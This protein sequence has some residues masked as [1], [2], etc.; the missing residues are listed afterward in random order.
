MACGVFAAPPR[1]P[2]LPNHYHKK[3]LKS[4][5]NVKLK[6]G[7]HLRCKRELDHMS[8]I[9]TQWHKC[10]HTNKNMLILEL[11]FVFPSVCMN[12][13]VLRLCLLHKWNPGLTTEHLTRRKLG[14]LACLR[15][16][17][18]SVTF[19]VFNKGEFN[20]DL[21]NLNFCWSRRRSLASFDHGLNLWSHG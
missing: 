20:G 6:H 4:R 18:S 10:R 1:P 9:S 5:T 8:F 16:E 12:S 13:C 7:F 19:E 21:R 3:T 15:S 11:A 17:K 14:P 2:V